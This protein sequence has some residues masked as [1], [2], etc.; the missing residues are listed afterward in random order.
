MKFE[1]KLGAP[2]FIEF[3][4]NSVAVL[5]QAAR[6]ECVVDSFPKAKLQYFINGKEITVKDHGIK[7]ESDAKTGKN[8]LI[9]PKVDSFY[10][11]KYLV[12]A[13]NIV[14][15]VECNFELDI[16]GTIIFIFFIFDNL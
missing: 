5:D 7:L 9:I 15:S 13:S 6:V 3:P 11:G 16:L 14:D 2:R 10:M 4:K 1:I 12:K 8:V